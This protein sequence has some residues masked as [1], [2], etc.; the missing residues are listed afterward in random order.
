VEG[1]P[2]IFT[3]SFFSRKI[4]HASLPKRKL[5]WTRDTEGNFS[6]WSLEIV[7]R[8]ESDK[9][10][11]VSYHLHKSVVGLGHRSSQYFLE[12]FEN[13]RSPLDKNVSTIELTRQAANLVPVMLDY[14]YGFNGEPLNVSTETAATLRHL[15]DQF[16][17]DTMFHEVNA[18]IQTD[19]NMTNVG[20][21]EKYGEL[22][23]DEQLL[24]AT[25]TLRTFGE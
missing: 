9:D 24:E 22:Y 3:D 8:E 25:K 7:S 1:P 12:E 11:L 10:N 6:D 4:R 2:G 13:Y 20:I 18:F 17:V 14:I 23:K 16:G 15:A 5:T 19:M 21:Y